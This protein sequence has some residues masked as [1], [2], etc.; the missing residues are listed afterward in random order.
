MKVSLSESTK[1][2]HKIDA[3]HIVIIV[4]PIIVAVTLILGNLDINGGQK[5]FKKL[6]LETFK[7]FDCDLQLKYL[8]S[9]LPPET[10]RQWYIDHCMESKP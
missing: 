4:I 2:N 8:I 7:T 5:V 3:F 9:T 10:H 6:P 1:S